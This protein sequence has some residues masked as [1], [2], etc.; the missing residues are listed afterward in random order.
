MPKKKQVVDDIEEVE[1]VAPIIPASIKEIEDVAIALSKLGTSIKQAMADSSFNIWD[2]K[3]FVDDI[4]ALVA[5]ADGIT[6]IPEDLAEL[7]EEGFD[8]V[9]DQLVLAVTNLDEVEFNEA[10][11]SVVY[12]ACHF[13]KFLSLIRK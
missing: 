6:R 2:L 12:A 13:T 4:P 5:A 11:R 9:V 7:D 1:E 3:F 8:R 10:T